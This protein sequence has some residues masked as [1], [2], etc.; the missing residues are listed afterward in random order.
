MP[1]ELW[2]EAATLT[3][4]FGLN[5]VAKA[6]NLGYYGLK[7]RVDGSSPKPTRKK[8]QSKSPKF[9]EVSLPSPEPP[10]PSSV[11]EVEIVRKDGTQVRFRHS[12]A[13][14]VADL[15]SRACGDFR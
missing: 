5:R 7:Q 1:E 4:R 14:D 13:L 9:V 6:L 8:S 3:V 11:T 12:G 10:P 2:Q 15:V